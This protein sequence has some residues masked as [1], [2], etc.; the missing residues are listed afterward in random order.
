[1]NKLRPIFYAAT[2]YIF[3]IILIYSF[4][5]LGFWQLDRAKEKDALQEAYITGENHINIK[6]RTDMATY[7]RIQASGAFD[8]DRQI[9][10]DNIIRDGQLGQ[11][12]I[13][14]FEINKNL[15]LLLVNRGWIKKENDFPNIKIDSSIIN[16]KGRSGSLPKVGI[17]DGEAFNEITTWP[18]IGIYPSIEEIQDQIERETLPYILLLDPDEKNG[19]TR[20][21]EPR[22]STSAT[23]YGYSVQWFL[24]CFGVIIFL[25]IKLKRTLL[26]KNN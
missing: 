23:N 3:F 25:I 5:S 12:I 16:I 13:T 15:P 2:P 21:W 11:M 22:V 24:M 14:P 9:I 10:I 4:A 17:R 7:T 6:D 8:K 19:F 18:N 26:N 1:M 20:N